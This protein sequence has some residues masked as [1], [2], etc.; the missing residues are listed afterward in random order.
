MKIMKYLADLHEGEHIND[1]YLIKTKVSAVTKNGKPY[2]NLTITDKTASL[3]AK[4]WEPNSEGIEEFE[5]LDYVFISGDVSSYQGALQV[6]IKRLRVADEGEYD[7]ADYLPVSSN[8]AEKMY[9]DLKTMINTVSNPNLNKLLKKF[10]EEDEDFIKRFRKSSAAKQIHHG[11]VGGLLEHTLSVT[12]LCEYYTKAY[13]GLNHD[14]LITSALLHDIGKTK[15]LSPFP[16]NDYTDEGQL[17]GHI[18]MGATMIT[19][20][21]GE[22]EEFPERLLNELVHCILAH[23]GE[24]EFGSPKKP[25]LMEALALHLAD[26]TDA[27]MESMK[28]IFLNAAGKS[29]WLG[30]NKIMESNI[31][32]TGEW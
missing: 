25:A 27:K 19:Q 28:E 23:H 20:K 21:A 3:N 4:I 16:Q 17:L 8:D 14:L 26:N 15:E 1:I 31:R 29:G 18:V 2:E 24:F 11:F 22:I 5:E 32:K 12:R 6:S 7:P 13:T 10:F 9:S 30:Y